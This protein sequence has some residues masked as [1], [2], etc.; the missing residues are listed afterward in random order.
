MRRGRDLDEE[1]LGEQFAFAERS[2]VEGR[3]GSQ[4]G[5]AATFNPLQRANLRRTWMGGRVA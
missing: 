5:A 3:G 2:A 1:L 4:F